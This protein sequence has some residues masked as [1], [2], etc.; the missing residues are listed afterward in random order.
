MIRKIKGL[1]AMVLSL[2]I[3]VSVTAFAA[4][5]APTDIAA[6]SAILMKKQQAMFFMKKMPTK[7]YIRQ[8]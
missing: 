1:L 4:P 3:V 5:S 2:C 6:V 7:K 8:A